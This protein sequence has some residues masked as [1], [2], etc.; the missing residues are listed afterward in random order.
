MT[1]VQYLSDLP[2]E[3]LW[4]NLDD[5]KPIVAARTSTKGALA[6]SE[7]GDGLV[8][9]LVRDRHG[10]PF[11]HMSLTARVTLPLF[12]W[13]QVVKHRAGVSVSRESGRYKE[14]EPLFYLPGPQRP[15]VQVGRPMAYQLEPGT[16]ALRAFVNG[17]LR[18]GAVTSYARYRRML[19]AGVTRE[20]ARTTLP[21]H[22]MTVGVITL[23]ARA[24]LHFLSLR[25]HRET[26]TYESHPQYEI[27]A[28]ADK[29][30]RVLEAEAPVTWRAFCEHG[31]VA[32]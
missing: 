22:I 17:E 2:V 18:T 9:A 4:H 26:A 19:E 6:G 16:E 13:E 30:E 1:D 27:E 12:T 28:L 23:N 31:R 20:L 32:P 3:V 21:E 8:N 5:D 11:E 25:T 15:L 24:L 29:L 14:L 10:V 7:R